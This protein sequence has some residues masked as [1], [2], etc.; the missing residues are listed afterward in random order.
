MMC[1]EPRSNLDL[2]LDE[3]VSFERALSIMAERQMRGNPAAKS[4][5]DALMYSLRAGVKAPAITAQSPTN[6]PS[7][8]FAPGAYEPDTSQ[9]SRASSL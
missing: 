1:A 4:T 7:L 3:N 8:T 9:R 2:L 5:I 6:I